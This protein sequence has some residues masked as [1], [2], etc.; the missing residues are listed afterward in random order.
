M[1]QNIPQKYQINYDWFHLMTIARQKNY[2]QRK[3]TEPLKVKKSKL[4][5][6]V[7]VLQ[8]VEGNHVSTNT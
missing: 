2:I 6:N 8:L 4:D 5:M 1:P 7:K 3:I